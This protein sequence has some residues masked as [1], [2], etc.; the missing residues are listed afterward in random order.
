MTVPMGVGHGFFEGKSNGENQFLAYAIQRITLKDEIT[1][2]LD[3][4]RQ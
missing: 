4:F 3:H 1:S 2:G